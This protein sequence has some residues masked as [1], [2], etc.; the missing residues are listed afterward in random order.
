MACILRKHY[1]EV[2]VKYQWQSIRSTEHLYNKP[3]SAAPLS[4]R[5]AAR[6]NRTID[7]PS[8][9]TFFLKGLYLMHSGV[10]Y[11]SRHSP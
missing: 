11:L 5:M 10:P 4:V 9:S 3:T 6:E 1:A 2:R 7:G 8:S